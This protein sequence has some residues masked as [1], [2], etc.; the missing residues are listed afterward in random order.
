MRMA[1]KKKK[2]K[3]SAAGAEGLGIIRGKNIGEC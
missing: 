1:K 3:K 2:K